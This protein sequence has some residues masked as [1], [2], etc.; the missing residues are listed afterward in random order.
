ML[1]CVG[2]GDNKHRTRLRL[3]N[4]LLVGERDNQRQ[5]NFPWPVHLVR[6]ASI[7]PRLGETL[8]H[9]CL[10]NA[11]QLGQPCGATGGADGL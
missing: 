1:L 2:M 5:H 8:R 7:K 6:V 11:D 3:F 9:P 10:A 4:F